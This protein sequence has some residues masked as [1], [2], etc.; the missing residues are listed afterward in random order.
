MDFASLKN[1]VAKIEG[2]M[3]VK[4]I[5]ENDEITEVHILANNLRAPKQ[6]VRDIESSLLAAF[7]YRIDRKIISIAQI[8]TD[9]NEALRRIK[10]S[11]IDLKTEGNALECTVSLLHDGEEFGEQITGIKTAANRKKI[12]ADAAVRTI[13]KILGQAYLFN[14]EDVVVN[15]SRDI[16]YVSVLVNMVLDENEQTMVGSAIVK[17]DVNEAIAKAT[18]DAVN[19]R[20]Q[21]GSF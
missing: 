17:H 8:Q 1:M 11:G 18:L 7:D 10:Y 3:N 5:S 15:T 20:I 19:R 14:I 2:V 16:T 12:V 4:V 21:R 9:D 13:E 6:I